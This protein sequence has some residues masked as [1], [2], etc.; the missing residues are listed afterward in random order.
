MGIFGKSNGGHFTEPWMF[1]PHVATSGNIAILDKSNTG[2]NAASVAF[3]TEFANRG[4]ID[5]TNWTA[6]TYKTLVS[7]TGTGFVA[8]VIGPEA[9]GADITTFEFTVDGVLTTMA[10]TS[11]SGM[12]A[13]ANTGLSIGS[14]N[15]GY[16]PQSLGDLN[17]SKNTIGDPAANNKAWWSWDSV[18]YYGTPLLIFR[19][20]LLIRAKHAQNITNSTATA[21]SGVMYRVGITA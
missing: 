12:R 19:N 4:A 17:G 20:S 9:A 10:I 21:Y 15:A 6:N 2:S 14:T 7:V 5:S 16:V 8:G 11:A 13:L 1:L 18:T 3:F